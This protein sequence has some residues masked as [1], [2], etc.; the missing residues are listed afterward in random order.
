MSRQ[1]SRQHRAGKLQP[2]HDGFFP[3]KSQKTRLEILGSLVFWVGL[4]LTKPAWSISPV[5]TA[6]LSVS[7]TNPKEPIGFTA[8][9]QDADAIPAHP[10]VLPPD[11]TEDTLKEWAQP[12]LGK[13]GSGGAGELRSGGAGE[14]GSGGAEELRS[15]EREKKSATFDSNLVSASPQVSTSEP[16]GE[17]SSTQAQDG[18]QALTPGL[19]PVDSSPSLP[20][21]PSCSLTQELKL[22]PEQKLL[23]NSTPSLVADAEN[24]P[25]VEV[26]VQPSPN[27]N[28]SE[29]QQPG[30]SEDPELGKLRL[31]EL[32]APP[33]PSKPAVYLLGGVGYFRSNNI[34]SGIDPI[35]DGVF[36]AGLTLLATPSLGPDTTLLA[37]VGGNINRYG[38]LSV[39]DYDELN[40]NLG[41]RQKIGSRS[42]G[43]VGWSNRQLFSQNSGDRFLNDHSLYLEL[44]RRDV[45]AKQL[46]LDTFYQLRVSLANPSDRSGVSNYVGAS[47]GYTPIPPLEVA[48]DYQFAFADFTQQERQDQYHQLL[49]RMSYTLTPN[50]RAYLYAGSS[51]GDSS[52]PDIDFDGF[53]FGAGVNFNL[54][55]F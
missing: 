30:S 29:S 37:A 27:E 33:P 39:Y 26:E 13:R 3:P 55:L 34:L 41:L 11:V 12:L 20:V 14:R 6:A 8:P 31:R 16:E 10:E 42:Y 46:T 44:G 1:V 9:S 40:F 25:N 15:E 49:A 18:E 51:F 36:R 17:K 54:T 50:S 23:C 7:N 48:L 38:E 47:L 53:V 52:R 35:D 22:T 45:L 21:T 43:E 2:Q 5:G 19:S 24:A 32:P 4:T 28:S